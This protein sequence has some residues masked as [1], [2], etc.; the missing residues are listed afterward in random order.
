M[1]VSAD[2][3]TLMALIGLG[4]GIDYALFIVTRHRHG[5]LAGSDIEP[6]IVR[7]VET[8]GRAVAFA[9]IIVCIAVLGM[10]T[11][12]VNFLYRIGLAA[13]IGV[14]GPVAGSRTPPPALR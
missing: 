13:A 7:S 10:F 9:G 1:S 11:L 3:S 2:A 8:S 14:A 4:V 12:G 6:S 5:V